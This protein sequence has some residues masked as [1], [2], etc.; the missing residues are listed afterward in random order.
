MDVKYFNSM[1]YQAWT[2]TDIDCGE[3]K[4]ADRPLD[5]RI[6]DLP[7]QEISQAITFTEFT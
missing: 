2:T 5:I 4:K 3:A 1:P 7:D 6:P